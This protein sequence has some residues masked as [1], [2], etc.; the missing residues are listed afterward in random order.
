MNETRRIVCLLVFTIL[1]LC[2]PA[3][4][5]GITAG[6]AGQAVVRG[7][8]ITFGELADISGSDEDRVH[9][10]RNLKL[11]EAPSPGQRLV[12]SAEILGARLMATGADLTDITWQM[13]PT[14]TITTALQTI[15]ADGLAM[16]AL[17]ALRQRLGQ[18]ADSGDITITIHGEVRDI[19]VPL[20]VIRLTPTFKTIHYNMPTTVTLDISVDDRAFSSVNVKFDL[21]LFRDVVIAARDIAAHEILTAA[22]L[23]LERLEVGHQPG[24]YLTD[25]SRVIGLVTRRAL[26]PGTMISAALLEK[27]L[28]VRQGV[29]VTILARSGSLEVSAPGQALQ[30]GKAGQLIRVQN[31]QSGKIILA[32]VMDSSTVLA[33]TAR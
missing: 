2:S 12:L 3:W 24:G 15:A 31:S 18:S 4:A 25:V 21:L 7:P 11:G 9:S 10:L 29:A 13:P 1:V 14:V 30:D 33:Y 28:L 26:P 16:T 32:Q 19:A 20:G 5:S 8:Q 6:I 23:H 27:P 17:T 22:D